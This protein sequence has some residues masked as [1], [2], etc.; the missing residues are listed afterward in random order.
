[1]KI[2]QVSIKNYRSCEDCNFHPE[3]DLSVLIGPNGSGKTNILSAIKILQSLL[4]MGR[5]R[6]HYKT[7]PPTTASSEIRTTFEWKGKK[8]VHTA[9]INILVNERNEDEIIDA[10]ESWY[11][12]D[13]TRSRKKIN[14][15]LEIIYDAGQFRTTPLPRRKA[16]KNYIE[17]LLES[18]INQEVFSALSDIADFISCF[19]YYS[20][21]QFTNPAN[22]PISFEVESSSLTGISRSISARNNHHKIFLY[23]LYNE[24]KNETEAYKEFMDIVGPNGIHL[25]DDIDFKEVETSSYRVRVLTGG[26]ITKHEKV[27]ILVVPGFTISS[28]RLSPSQLSEGTFKTL[29]LIFNLVTDKSSLLMIEEPEVCVHHGLLSSIVELINQY[30]SEKQIIIS[31]HSDT[32]IDEIELRNIFAVKRLD[33]SGTQVNQISK[34]MDRLELEALKEYLQTEG[35]LGEFWRNGDLENV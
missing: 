2:S 5:R 28:S 10:I 16:S 6:R 32:V 8:I 34:A 22:S 19:N 20:A 23:E 25:V 13:I 21:S 17:Y 12:F 26:D 3:E 33:D 18:G 1:M 9:I 29:A 4:F 30:S 15:P 11:A 27:N 24:K 31:T 7:E 14:I 35:S